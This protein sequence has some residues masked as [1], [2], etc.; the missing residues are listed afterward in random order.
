MT[1]LSLADDDILSQALAGI[2]TTSSPSLTAPGASSSR[3]SG[4]G[5]VGGESFGSTSEG[6]SIGNQSHDRITPLEL[7]LKTMASISSE[8]S[9][10]RTSFM[11]ASEIV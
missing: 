4:G 6:V 10:L 7:G 8:G 11:L 9:N 2:S 5:R 3:S 1:L